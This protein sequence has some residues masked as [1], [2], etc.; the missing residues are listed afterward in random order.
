MPAGKTRRTGGRLRRPGAERE[1][2]EPIVSVLQG[3][4]RRG[5]RGRAADLGIAN[6]EKGTVDPFIGYTTDLDIY[7]QFNNPRLAEMV[8]TNWSAR[9]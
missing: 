7:G 4:G 1:S 9:D 5:R 2:L 3:E 6:M 8:R